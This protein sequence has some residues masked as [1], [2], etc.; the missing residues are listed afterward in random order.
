MGPGAP[1]TV[2]VATAGGG[3][4][5]AEGCQPRQGPDHTEPWRQLLGST[6]REIRKSCRVRRRLLQGTALSVAFRT[7]YSMGTRGPCEDV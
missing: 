5:G 3:A 4:T 2:E 6:P 7:G 1:D